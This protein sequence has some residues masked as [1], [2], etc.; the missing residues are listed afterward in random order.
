LHANEFQYG[1]QEELTLFLS[2]MTERLS[3][4]HT[5]DLPRLA[6]LDQQAPHDLRTPEPQPAAAWCF[7]LSFWES[8]FHSMAV[9]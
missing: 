1:L 6:G 7:I 5:S 3:R 2:K 8:P 4:T 9:C